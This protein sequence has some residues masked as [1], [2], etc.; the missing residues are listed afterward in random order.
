MRPSNQSRQPGQPVGLQGLALRFCRMSLGAPHHLMEDRNGP[1]CKSKGHAAASGITSR[2]LW[3]VLHQACLG[4]SPEQD[5][6]F[7][8]SWTIPWLFRRYS[9]GNL[10]GTSALPP[11][12]AGRAAKALS[13]SPVQDGWAYPRPPV[14]PWSNK[15]STGYQASTWTGT[16]G[17][18]PPATGGDIREAEQDRQAHPLA[19]SHR[20]GGVHALL[21][22]KTPMII[23]QDMLRV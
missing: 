15:R 10:P 8:R 4:Q 19:H 11:T 12:D 22:L 3:Q 1:C 5:R 13:L 9:H 21:L 7:K 6:R 18:M 23:H 17:R 20:A 14:K 16:S 2:G